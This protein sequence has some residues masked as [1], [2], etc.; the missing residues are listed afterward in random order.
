LSDGGN[1]AFTFGDDR[2]NT[3]KWATL[4]IDSMAFNTITPDDFEVVD[5]GA[6]IA[7]TDNC[8]RNP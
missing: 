3:A 1:V 6:E 5:L 8:V 7:L 2:L 4:G